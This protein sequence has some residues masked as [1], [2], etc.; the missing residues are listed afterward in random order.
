MYDHHISRKWLMLIILILSTVCLGMIKKMSFQ[1][2]AEQ[3]KYSGSIIGQYMKGSSPCLIIK[4]PNNLEDNLEINLPMFHKKEDRVSSPVLTR[5]GLYFILSKWYVEQPPRIMCLTKDT[6]KE[7]PIVWTDDIENLYIQQL[8]IYEEK[9]YLTLQ[10]KDYKSPDKIYSVPKKGGIAKEVYSN[11]NL[12]GLGDR[13]AQTDGI[14][15][16]YKDGLICIRWGTPTVVFVNDEKEDVLFAMPIG[17]ALLLKGWYEEGKSIVLW[18]KE[19]NY[20]VVV[21]LHGNVIREIYRAWFGGT[22][23]WDIHG[24]ADNGILLRTMSIRDFDYVPGVDTMFFFREENIL[25]F[26]SGVYDTRTGNMIP[27]HWRNF[28]FPEGWSKVDYDKVF[29]DKLAQ[30]ALSYP[31]PSK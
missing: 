5:D 13:A 24:N 26:D 11:L 17:T 7:L 18:S 30:S 28:A 20:G 1:H 29:L 12:H 23:C 19:P 14:P 3:T 31:I 6:L 21:D 16:Q 4:N 10:S 22:M 2:S 15:I 9:I 25:H 27:L 8:Y